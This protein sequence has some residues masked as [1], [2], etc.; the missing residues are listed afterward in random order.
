MHILNWTIGGLLVLALFLI[1]VNF[2]NRRPGAQRMDGTRLFI[3]AWLVASLFNFY[4][5]WVGHGIPFLN[6]VAAFVPI[7]GIPAATAWFWSRR[8]R[9]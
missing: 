6:E 1:A 2:L 8:G 7:F 4:D 9:S 3:G 5:G